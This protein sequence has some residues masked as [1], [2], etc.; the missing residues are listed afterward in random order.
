[1]KHLIR[2]EELAMFALSIALFPSLEFQWWW[3]PTLIFLPDISMGGYL[4]NAKAGARLYNLFHHK[5]AGLLVYM[6]GLFAGNG[7][8]QLCGLI[9]FG[10][11]SLDRLFGYGL[12][13]DDSFRHTHLGWIGA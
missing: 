8:A 10:H 3:Y 1:M 12:K 4:L 11:A 7:T 2:L 13:F 9:L 6:I 5:G